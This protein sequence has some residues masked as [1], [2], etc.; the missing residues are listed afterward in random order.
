MAGWNLQVQIADVAHDVRTGSAV[1]REARVRGTSVYFVPI[2]PVADVL[3]EGESIWHVLVN[4]T[5]KRWSEARYAKFNAPGPM[6][7]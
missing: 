6:K 2:A 4:R 1:D 7:S 3:P 5:R